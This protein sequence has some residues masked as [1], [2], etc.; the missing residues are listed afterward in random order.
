M[1]T[2]EKV[3]DRGILR[4]EAGVVQAWVP[5]LGATLTCC[6]TVDKSVTSLSI[7]SSFKMGIRTE[8]RCVSFLGL[9]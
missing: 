7:I 1:V 4:G 6:V 3:T 8:G 9:L 5:I 2:R